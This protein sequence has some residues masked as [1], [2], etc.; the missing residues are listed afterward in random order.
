MDSTTEILVIVEEIQLGVK[1]LILA[2]ENESKHIRTG[3]EL[4]HQVSE[5][6]NKILSGAK[7]TNKAMKKISQATLNEKKATS[8]VFTALKEIQQVIQQ[9]T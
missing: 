9:S 4:T 3:A 7:S 8:Q 5:H 2:S 6:L 1:Q